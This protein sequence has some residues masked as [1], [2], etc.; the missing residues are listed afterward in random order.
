MIDSEFTNAVELKDVTKRYGRSIAVNQL[1]LTI[2]RGETFGLIGPNGAGKSTTIKLMM[3][4]TSIDGGQALVLG[5]DVDVD[6]ETIKQ[7]VGYVPEL[8]HIYRW[9]RIRDVLVFTRSFYPSWNDELCED[10]LSL[11]ELPLDK[12]VRGLS[13]GMLAKLG[14]LVAVA[15]EPKLLVLDEPTSGL[16]PIVRQEFLDGVLKTICRGD[17][18]VLFSSHAIDDV[19]RL[20][21]S[22]GIVCEG[23]MLTVKPVERLLETT[24]RVR[25]ILRDGALPRQKPETMIFDRLDRREWLVTV[26]EYSPSVLEVLE[27]NNPT[28]SVAVEDMSLEEAFT[29]Y[30][31]GQRTAT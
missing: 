24:K 1:S 15:H 25:A 21:D 13:K 9:M 5:A 8:H 29:D 7:H 2:K 3:G 6:H 23:R 19:A 18:T 22:V 20:A 16:D 26:G 28:V 30:I 31:R 10:L 27:R 12:R 14:L 4:L 17:Q 11:F